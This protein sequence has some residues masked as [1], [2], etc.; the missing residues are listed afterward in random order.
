VV[1]YFCRAALAALATLLD[2]TLSGQ[3][4]VLPN[5]DSSRVCQVDCVKGESSSGKRG[6]NSFAIDLRQ[7]SIPESASSIFWQCYRLPGRQL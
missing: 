2:E 1:G 7:A 6:P 3:R 4:Q 5:A